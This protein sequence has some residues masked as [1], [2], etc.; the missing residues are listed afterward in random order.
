MDVDAKGPGRDVD[1]GLVGTR[2]KVTVGA[3]DGV[4]GATRAD[5]VA[6]LRGMGSSEVGR[7]S[8]D[9]LDSFCEGGEIAGGLYFFSDNY[10]VPN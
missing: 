8:C 7:G 2:D 3:C 9:T 10:D 1:K 6:E 5:E 4:N